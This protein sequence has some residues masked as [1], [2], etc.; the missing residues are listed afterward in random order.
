MDVRAEHVDGSGGR[1]GPDGEDVRRGTTA[2][3]YT[4]SL[5]AATTYDSTV[6]A[7]L[8]PLAAATSLGQCAARGGLG[9]TATVTSGD[10]VSDA[11]GCLEV[12][13]PPVTVKKSVASSRQL[14]DG[15]WQID[16]AVQMTNSSSTTATVYTL[17]DTP[18]LGAGFTV[19]SGA[20]QTPAPV[21]NTTLAGKQVDT[22][23]YRVVAS[24]DPETENLQLTPLRSRPARSPTG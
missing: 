1:L 23:T 9:N 24:F 10:V 6:S 21:A 12:T 17:T 19:V 18:R 2:T 22:Y 20:W 13:T 15:T 11:A 3:I 7:T 8:V 5:S 16:D 14:E 4:G